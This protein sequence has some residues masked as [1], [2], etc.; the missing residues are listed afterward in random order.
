MEFRTLG[1]VELWAAGQ[2]HDLGPARGR[3]LLVMMLLAPRTMLPA[4]TFIDRLWDARPPPKARENLSVYMARLRSSLR[5][6]VGDDVRLLGRGQGGY[7]LELD[8]QTIDVHR[9]RQLRRQATALAASGNHDQAT[10]L[11]REAEG[12]WRGE[13]LAGIRGDWAARMRDALEEE[14]RAVI[15]E[16]VACDLELGRHADLVGELRHLLARY[17]LDETLVAQ[18]MTALYRTGRQADA[19]GLYRETRSRLIEDQGTEPGAA[20]SELQQRILGGDPALAIGRD[21]R[22]PAQVEIPDML[23]PEVTDFV[24]RDD[25]LAALTSEPAGHPAVAVIEG[26][27]GVGK[28]TL[29]VRAARMLAARY[30]DGLL[31]LDLHSHDPQDRSLQPAEALHHL[32]RMLSVPAAQIPKALDERVALWR[33]HLSRRRVVVILDDAAGQDQIRP[34]LPVA[35]LCLFL[36]TTRRRLPN[37]DG[38]RTVALDLLT[39]EEGATLFRRVAGEGRA[40][41]AG[42]VATTVALCG[43]LPLAIR[44]TAGR[45]A[46]AND[47]SLSSLIEEM[48]HSPV[49]PNGNGTATPEVIAA[50]E[51]SYRALEPAY[52]R[53]FRCLGLSPCSTHSRSAAAALA[54]CT[55]EDAET[56]LAVLL[57]A[58]LLTRSADNQYRLHDL[59]RGYAAARARHD[60]PESEQKRA[61]SRL[62]DYYLWAADQ[63]HR[64]LHPRWRR[65]PVPITY[66]PAA[67]PVFVS[68]AAATNWLESECHNV[69]Q[70]AVYAGR[71]EWK[72]SCA[73][74]S[75]LLA[76]FLEIKAHWEEAITVHDLALQAS[77]Y[78]GDQAR[79]A[80][81]ALALS[82][83]RQHTGRYE[84]AIPLAEEA[85]AIYGRL[86]DPGGEAESLDQIGL[87]SQRTARSREALAYF[88]QARILY[89][90]AGDLRG[91]ANTLSHSGIACW[92]LGRHREAQS[93]LLHAFSLYRT[94][95]DRRGEAKALNNLGRVHLYDGRDTDAL[96]AYE[97][98]LRIFHEIGG[99]QNE[100]ILHQ[101]IGS[102][103]CYRGSYDEALTACRQALGIYRSIG[104]LPDEADVLNDI[105]TIYQEAACPD[106]ALVHHQRAQLIAEEIGD[107]SQRLIALRRIADIHRSCGRPDPAFENYDLALSLAREIGNP[108]EEGKIL[109]G[110]GELTLYT[111]RREAA[112]IVLR[113]AL[114]IFESLDV[115]E[116]ESTRL[117]IE[118]IDPA[119]AGLAERTPDHGMRASA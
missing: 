114:D 111:Q 2:R 15:I 74:L 99:P 26:M 93:H 72:Q 45:F 103:H 22:R 59:L 75:Y 104:D 13:A 67:S 44:V 36:V 107:R 80:R 37:L 64:V 88:Q 102:V 118:A 58:H 96:E 10:D 1:P 51:L 110:I 29:A 101:A 90:T 78:L 35:G 92:H 25:E 57:D 85:A 106:E 31:H 98:S 38:S 66:P 91:V 20:L 5:R 108:Y 21:A 43:R 62:L 117:R 109:E 60:D 77:R 56:A 47:A 113:Q 81:A 89:E 34:L 97:G 100:A 27:P 115:P 84:A 33:A 16:R 83:V 6:A 69:L 86:A 40:L 49:S 76:D 14:R 32:L 53:F 42:Q 70:A 9:F 7:L 3:A 71:H 28:T 23:P 63:A 61:V 4:E 82:V 12:L 48:S 52:Q 116:A 41:D 95:G 112:R 79:I 65:L 105:G 87:A 50:F 19:L 54:G 18:Q 11:L 8:P 119:L 94:I 46:Q 55:A 68:Q 24:G 39:T 73:D 30:P 17:P